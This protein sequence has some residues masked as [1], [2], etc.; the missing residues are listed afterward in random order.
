MSDFYCPICNMRRVSREGEICSSC[1]DPY[2]T[3][4][5]MPGP[6]AS[7]AGAGGAAGTSASSDGDD[8]GVVISSRRSGR[9]IIGAQPSGTPAHKS[10]RAIHTG[11][12]TAGQTAPQPG[13][14][15]IVPQVVSPVAPMAPSQD[16][17]E[18]EQ[19]AEG[20]GA[21]AVEGIV[22]NVTTSK[23]QMPPV[24]RWFRS[25]VTDIPFTL[26]EDITEFQVYSN[27][28]GTASQNGYCAD[29]VVAYGTM[30]TGKPIQDN[31]VRVYGKR[32]KNR[33]I[34]ATDIENTVDG[35]FTV[36]EPRPIKAR[37][38]K[39]ITLG[40]ALLLI[41]PSLGAVFSSSG[42]SAAAASVQ[43]GGFNFFNLLVGLVAGA[44]AFLTGKAAVQKIGNDW[45]GCGINALIT[46]GLA[47]ACLLFLGMSF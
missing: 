18:T 31:S 27:W 25:L 37:T 13:Q 22:K 41:L 10:V 36:F 4:T 32:D 35:T 44:G 45:K 20:A 29:K 33:M 1:Q 7:M 28:T 14:Q 3:G 43:G 2:E 19:Q 16:Q 12:G 21:P 11:G 47:Y 39:L 24:S 42:G 40:I 26:S 9:V 30:M 17:D 34:V 15:P 46:L 23:D 5:P 6:S 38:V 8:G